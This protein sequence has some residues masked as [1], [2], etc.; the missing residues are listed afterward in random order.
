MSV[1]HKRIYA[2]GVI[3]VA[4]L[5]AGTASA[6]AA[7]VRSPDPTPCTVSFLLTA[8]PGASCTYSTG[9][10]RRQHR[11]VVTIGRSNTTHN[12]IQREIDIASPLTR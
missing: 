8:P 10:G 7:P 12:T 5:A 11:E 9:T 2:A 3:M 1:P 4:G 6:A